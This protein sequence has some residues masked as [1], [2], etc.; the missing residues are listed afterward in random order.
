M[1]PAER[2]GVSTPC[3]Q[4]LGSWLQRCFGDSTTPKT[5][6]LLTVPTER[7]DNSL[8]GFSRWIRKRTNPYLRAAQHF[9]IQQSPT[10]LLSS[11]VNKDSVPPGTKKQEQELFIRSWY[12]WIFT[13]IFCPSHSNWSPQVQLEEPIPEITGLKHLLLGQSKRRASPLLSS[14]FC[15]WC[16][17][18]WDWLL[19]EMLTRATWEGCEEEIPCQFCNGKCNNSPAGYWLSC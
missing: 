14:F 6:A 7:L 2:V 11:L 19:K 3:L 13:G 15:C 1:K 12:C 10:L 17:W 8:P 16:H 4:L 5:E 9:K 18:G